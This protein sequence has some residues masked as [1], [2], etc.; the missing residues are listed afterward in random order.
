MIRVLIA[1]G[2][3]VFVIVLMISVFFAANRQL[4]EAWSTCMTELRIE[5]RART[6]QYPSEVTAL[7]AEAAGCVNQRKSFLAGLAFGGNEG[8][9]HYESRIRAIMEMQQRTETGLREMQEDYRNM[10]SD[11]EAQQSLQQFR[12]DAYRGGKQP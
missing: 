12:E 2:L 7:M 6:S 4:G 5:E 1:F 3:L 11:H 8:F 9:E 10:Q